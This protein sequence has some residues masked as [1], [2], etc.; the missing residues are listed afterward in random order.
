[1]DQL[2][3]TERIKKFKETGDSR[4][5][6]QNELDKAYFQQDM[7]Y[8][9]FKDLRRRIVSDKMLRDKAFNITKNQKNDWYQRG[10]AWMVYKFFDQKSALLACM[11]RDLSYVR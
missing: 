9:D 3:K 10:L 5:I 6:Y 7:A 4:D 11:V 8:G 1:M 2:Q